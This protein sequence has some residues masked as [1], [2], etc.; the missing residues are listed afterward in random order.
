MYSLVMFIVSLQG[1]VVAFNTVQTFG[2]KLECVATRSNIVPD[3]VQPL[4][5]IGFQVV[6]CAETKDASVFPTIYNC[7][8]DGR[9][10][11]TRHAG[12]KTLGPLI[13]DWIVWNES[14]VR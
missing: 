5:R 7:N 13:M 11:D 3:I 6:D 1:D 10:N 12:R 2:T 9:C 8:K 4:G 14:N